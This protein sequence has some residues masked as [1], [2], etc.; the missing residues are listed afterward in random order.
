MHGSTAAAAG[1]WLPTRAASTR[2][3]RITVAG[4]TSLFRDTDPH[5][6]RADRMAEAQTP[7]AA[8]H[9][10]ERQRWTEYDHLPDRAGAGHHTRAERTPGGIV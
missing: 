1:S 2:G 8:Q 4:R 7:I 6:K 9:P 3:R 10:M 5:R